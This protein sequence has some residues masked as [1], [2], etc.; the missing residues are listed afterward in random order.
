MKHNQKSEI[1]KFDEE[2]TKHTQKILQSD[3]FAYVKKLTNFVKGHIVQ[4]SVAGNS[5]FILFLDNNSWV[6]SFLRDEKVIYKCAKGQASDEDIK[7]IRPDEFGDA[8]EPLKV[9]L[10]YSNKG[11]DMVSEIS[12]SHGKKITGISIGEDSFNFCF[13][14]RLELETMLVPDK[15]GKLALRV[16]WEQW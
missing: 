8:S 11:C 5:G 3:Y 2:L 1:S 12:N 13:P 4:N 14:G 15:K 9:D 7:L 10:P 16:F 6:A